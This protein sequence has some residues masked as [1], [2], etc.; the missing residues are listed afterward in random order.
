MHCSLCSV[1][2]AYVYVVS[3]WL[4]W[5]S[6]FALTVLPSVNFKGPS[7]L[8]CSSWI[9]SFFS[10]RSLRAVNRILLNQHPKDLAQCQPSPPSP[11]T[12]PHVFFDVFIDVVSIHEF[13]H[14]APV[15]SK[16][17]SRLVCPSRPR[18][19]QTSNPTSGSEGRTRRAERASRWVYITRHR[20][21]KE[22]GD[23]EVPFFLPPDADGKELL[24]CNGQRT[25]QGVQEIK[26]TWAKEASIRLTTYISSLDFFLAQSAF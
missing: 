17:S 3:L 22:R 23:A 6:L 16:G 2:L 1:M 20:R 8:S 15:G 9:L 4:H 25:M 21:C 7:S 24:H 5:L 12:P 13:I 10:C 11:P 18:T 26:K 19:P 14:F